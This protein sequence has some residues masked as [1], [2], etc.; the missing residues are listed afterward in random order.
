[1][2]FVSVSLLFSALVFGSTAFASFSF[3]NAGAVYFLTND[4]SGNKV[5]SVNIGSNGLLGP[6]VKGFST[7][8]HGLH[9]ITTPPPQAADAIFSQG[10]IA[11]NS[12]AKLLAAVNPGSNSVSLFRINPED[13][14]QLTLVG[15]PAPSAGE[16]PVSVAINSKATHA[17]VLNGGKVNGISCFTI[18]PVFGLIPQPNTV[19]FLKRNQTT[20]ANGPMNALSQVIFSPDDSRVIAAV[21]GFPTAPGMSPS[22]YTFRFLA[23][24]TVS[25]D[26]SLSSEFVKSTP[27]SGGALPFSLTPIPGSNA[28][29]ATD[30]AIGV[31]IFDFGGT[32]GRSASLEATAS[33]TAVPGE[34]ALCWS[35]FS[36]KSG[37][38]YTVD[39]GTNLVTEVHVDKDL[40]AS[41]VK[42]YQLAG[43]SGVLDGEV[44]TIGSNDFLY[45]LSANEASIDVLSVNIPANAK[46]VQAFGFTSAAE[47][48]GV[49]FTNIN[50]QGLATF[51]KA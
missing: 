7:G 19:R 22:Q 40:K 48:A 41:L 5:V 31:D 8:G 11:I 12:K 32:D 47:K 36:T 50:I 1:M 4:P 23:T 3:G 10:S 46:I 14:T 39:T 38:F 44:A 49:T 17:C 43:T 20:P 24:W 37:N 15:R 25:P 16:F 35:T 6:S 13:P 29:L 34:V 9:G 2:L 42:Q 28:Y 33:V 45:V 30:P 26:G 27:A 21:K 18:H 51:I